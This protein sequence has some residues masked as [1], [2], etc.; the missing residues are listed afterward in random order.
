MKS[1]PTRPKKYNAFFGLPPE[2]H[3]KKQEEMVFTQFTYLI[4]QL[5]HLIYP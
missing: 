5:F 3:M 1:E 4:V 2:F